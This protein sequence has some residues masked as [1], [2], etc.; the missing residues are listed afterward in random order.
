MS[1]V[2]HGLDG[3]LSRTDIQRFHSLLDL[4]IQP[5]GKAALKAFV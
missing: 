5:P 3:W 2:I 4:P 1:R